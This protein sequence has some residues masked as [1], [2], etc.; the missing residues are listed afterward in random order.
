MI[1]IA[2]LLS[3][4]FTVNAHAI[5][6]KLGATNSFK[7]TI[8]DNTGNGIAG[9]D[10]N[11]TGGY[12]DFAIKFKCGSDAIVTMDETGDTIIDEGGGV[13]YVTTNDTLTTTNENEC[14]VWAVGEGNYVVATTVPTSLIAKTPRL[15][16]AIGATMDMTGIYKQV[17]VTSA[18]T[19]TITSTSGLTEASNKDY[20]GAVIN[21]P[22]ATA[23][24]N[25]PVFLKVISFNPTTDTITLNGLFPSALSAGDVCNVYIDTVR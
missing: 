10:V 24:D 8:T 7:V 20:V 19:S 17:T 9:L 12:S 2:I 21:C 3:L 5:D 6:K 18:T 25:R 15:I 16:K 23:A 11:A 4:I 14:V 22:N 13:Y 1:I